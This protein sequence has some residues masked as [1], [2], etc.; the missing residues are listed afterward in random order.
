ML[1]CAHYILPVTSEPIYDGAILVRDGKI[2][3]IG[4]ADQMKRLY[5]DEEVM[6]FEESALMP[7]MIDLHVHLEDT[8]MR[9]LVPDEPYTK[10][11]HTLASTGNKL[12]ARDRR[13]SAVLGGLE[14]LTSGITF[15]ADKSTTGASATAL[16]KLGMRGIVYRKV[17]AMD[18]SRVDHAMFSAHS[19]VLQ[20]SEGVDPSR[21][22]IGITPLPTYECHP[23]IFT[24]AAELAREE[25]IPLSLSVASSREEVDFLAYGGSD[26]SVDS[27]QGRRGFI[28]VPPWLP[29]GV[30]PVSYVREWGGFEADNV[31]AVHC[32][33]VDAHDINILKSA[34]VSVALCPRTNAQLSM[35]VAP[36]FEFM[37]SGITMGLGTGY[38]VA[39][40]STDLISEMRLGML[41]QRAVNPGKFLDAETML[42]LATIDAAR[43][44]KMDDVIGSLEIGK[45][46]DI[47]AVDLSSS[48]QSPTNDPASAVVN[49]TTGA[50]V[51]MT[52]VGGVIRYEKGK[53]H[54]GAD[55][56]KDIARV[57]E[58]RGKLRK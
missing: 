8:V 25:N 51:L 48:H 24:R 32:V 9:G 23:A 53:W 42:R 29:T 18:K 28:E 12:D 14:A 58:I 43:A 46:A 54:L 50:D 20:W 5:P 52:M 7:G 22:K 4:A 38:A 30:S 45:H 40:D 41:L 57:I 47:V 1:L 11:R 21:I 56:A 55:V 17:G 6:D 31:I 49:T 16:Q 19:D 36:L 34:G 39:T 44:V 37:R 15:V 10:W 35:G 2:A 26:L 3:E 13:S 27:M 33:H